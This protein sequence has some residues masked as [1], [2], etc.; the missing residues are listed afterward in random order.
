MSTGFVAHNG[1][2]VDPDLAAFVENEAAP[3]VGVDADVYW[4]AL[5]RV[6][7]EFTPRNRAL[8]AERTRIQDAIDAWHHPLRVLD[9]P[10]Q[11]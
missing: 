1:L 5:T 6:V 3:A 9:R 8:L 11:T 7:V 10:G 2:S 4:D